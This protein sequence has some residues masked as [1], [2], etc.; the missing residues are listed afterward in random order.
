VPQALPDYQ[1]LPSDEET[2][3][4]EDGMLLRFDRHSLPGEENRPVA[5]VSSG[6]WSASRSDRFADPPPIRL[7]QGF[8]LTQQ[9]VSDPDFPRDLR[10]LR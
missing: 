6:P 1:N 5:D 8:D 4:Q 2:L 7:G 3:R 10:C 9:A